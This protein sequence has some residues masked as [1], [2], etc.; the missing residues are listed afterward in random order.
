VN[1]RTS[2]WTATSAKTLSK[3]G[4][5]TAAIKGLDPKGAYEFRAVILHPLLKIYGQEQSMK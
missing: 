5:F 2:A 1:S 3:T 4:S